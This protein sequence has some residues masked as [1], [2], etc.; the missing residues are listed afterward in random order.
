[1]RT[2][3][4]PRV[5]ERPPVEVAPCLEQLQDPV[6][7]AQPATRCV[8]RPRRSSWVN[9]RSRRRS[10]D[11]ARRCASR[12]GQSA[13][14]W[15]APAECGAAPARC[16]LSTAS[17]SAVDDALQVRVPPPPGRPGLA[18]VKGWG[19]AMW[20]D[21]P[22]RVGST[23]SAPMRRIRRRR[24]ED[25]DADRSPLA[26]GHREHDDG[27][28]V[29]S[30]PDAHH[31]AG[32]RAR[33]VPVRRRPAR[34]DAG[35]ERSCRRRSSGLV[36]HD[37]AERADGRLGQLVAL[38]GGGCAAA[39][40][41]GPPPGRPGTG[42]SDRSSSRWASSAGS[43]APGWPPCCRSAGTSGQAEAAARRPGRPPRRSPRRATT[44]RRRAR[45][46]SMPRRPARPVSWVYWP[47]VRNSWSL[48]GELGEL[49]DHDRAG[50]HV[51]AQRQ[52]LGGEHDLD[53]ALRR[54]T[55]RRPP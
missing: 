29:G 33:R 12:S 45:S 13:T 31:V 51:D 34:G 15:S 19:S 9:S 4:S 41:A 2:S 22:G 23:S 21:H 38:L 42:R 43:A 40:P 32:A 6:E 1:M 10:R 27:A 11:S 7:H 44:A 52:R 49:V 53:Q 54:S 14:G 25:L 36:L 20:L 5:G 26:L 17:A 35:A 3:C 18:G 50:R 30:E 48:A 16:R 24:G 55:P 28:G 47:G 39:A 8:A 37:V 46:S